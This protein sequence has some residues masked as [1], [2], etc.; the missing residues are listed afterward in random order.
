MEHFPEL[1]ELEAV[2]GVAELVDTVLDLGSV[3]EAIRGELT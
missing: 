1:I 2:D 3:R